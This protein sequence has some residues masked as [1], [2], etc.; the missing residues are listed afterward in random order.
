M[1]GNEMADAVMKGAEKIAA[2]DIRETGNKI[3]DAVKNADLT[4]VVKSIGRSVSERV[5]KRTMATLD[6]AYLLANIDGWFS[7]KQ[8]A[9][10]E[11][12]AAS[13]GRKPSDVSANAVGLNAKLAH[14]RE[15][16]TEDELLEA[17][18]SE[19]RPYCESFGGHLIPSRRAFALWITLGLA[20]GEMT[21]VYRKALELLRREF[22]H[23]ALL[24]GAIG[25]APV[26]G[27]AS[28]VA[29]VGAGLVSAIAGGLKGLRHEQVFD[30]IAPL[31][32]T[33]FMENAETVIAEAS[34][35]E[36]QLAAA[37]DDKKQDRYDSLVQQ[38]EELIDPPCDD[39]AE[40]DDEED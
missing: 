15:K 37:P 4:G 19:C 6:V 33:D 9:C 31:I 16:V 13:L 21:P 10:F 39:D 32:S 18:I 3:V 25:A 40:E 23:S 24:F 27:A 2:V 26:I 7:E 8:E 22:K 28:V 14:I 34:L 5:E 20:D 38:L 17:F 36:N 29:G 11:K 35:L 30:K 1:K 12:I